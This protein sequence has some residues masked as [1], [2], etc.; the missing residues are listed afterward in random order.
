MEKSKPFVWI[1]CMMRWGRS[2][3]VWGSSL[4]GAESGSA[5]GVSGVATLINFVTGLPI[6]AMNFAINVPLVIIGFLILGKTFTA[7]NA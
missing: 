4:Y 6:G 1:A 7:K 2:F 5:G 3:T